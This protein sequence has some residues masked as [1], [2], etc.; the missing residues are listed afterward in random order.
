MP[1]AVIAFVIAAVAHR[2][3]AQW[4]PV[5]EL[6]IAVLAGMMMRTLGWVPYWAESGLQWVSEFPLRLGIVLLGLQLALRDL[7]VLG[8]EVL[9]IIGVT[10]LA[11]FLS[12]R[13]LGQVYGVERRTTSLVATGTAICGASAVAA[14]SAVLDRGDGKD[15]QGRVLREATA[16]ALPVVTLCGTAAMLS[17]PLLADAFG[18]RD[19]AAGVWIGAS[20]QEVGQVIAAGGVVGA[21]ALAVAT[22]VK[23]ARVLLLAPTL[24]AMRTREVRSHA[25]TM[26]SRGGQLR[27]SELLPWFVIGFLVMVGVNSSVEI[28]DGNAEFIQQVTVMFMT[29]A[30]AGVGAAVNLRQLVRTGGPVLLLGAS[31]T[32]VAAGT[33]L[34]GVVVLL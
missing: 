16:T 12:V 30:M 24:I 26:K 8:W 29:I 23:L 31:G 21:S 27:V 32:V 1:G 20:I 22:V 17:L 6:L 10:V 34:V 33:A 28:P 18:L 9:L 25:T 4:L 3:L 11:S 7:A 5:S 15:R 13:L 19:E 2:F 14:A